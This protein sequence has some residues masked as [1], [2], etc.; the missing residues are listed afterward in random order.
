MLLR[1]NVV[2]NCKVLN[3]LF[4]VW[5]EVATAR[6]AGQDVACTQ[7]H[8]TMLTEGVSTSQD[9]GDLFL[10]I[11]VVKANRASH[12]HFYILPLSRIRN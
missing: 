4:D 9:S 11:E 6:G 3:Q 2:Q 10:V 12:F 5:T 8:E 1:V 7:I